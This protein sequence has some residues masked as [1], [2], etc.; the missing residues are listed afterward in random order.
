MSERIDDGFSTLITFLD[1]ASG[2]TI[3]FWEKEVTPPGIEMGGANDTTTM[4]NEEWRTKAPK[5]LKS[6]TDGSFKAAYDPAVYDTILEIIG[7]NGQIQITFS[8][9]STL[10]FWGWLDKF[11]PG[12]ITE[13][14][15]PVADCT[16]ICSN[17]DN[18]KVE[19]PPVYAAG[20]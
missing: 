18:D 19:Q 1:A 3:S 13:G 5:K 7:V 8:D 20:A 15:Q 2:A 4:R 16:I 9:D 11:T 10:T 12:N 14:A 6:L 17:Q